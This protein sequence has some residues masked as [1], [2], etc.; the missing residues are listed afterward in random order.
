MRLSP[1]AVEE[2]RETLVNRI[3]ANGKALI[4]SWTT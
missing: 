4:D 3:V 1:E 2:E